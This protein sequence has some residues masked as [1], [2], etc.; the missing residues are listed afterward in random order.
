M[1]ACGHACHERVPGAI[2]FL[3]ARPEGLGPFAN[4]HT[5]Q[6]VVDEAA[7]AVGAALHA[8]M[9]LRLLDQRS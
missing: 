8:A 5:P 2:A 1:H 9:A 4:V 7:M 3:G 6:F